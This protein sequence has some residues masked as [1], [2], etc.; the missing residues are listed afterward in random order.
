[1]SKQHSSMT[2]SELHVPFNSGLDANKAA[3][4][5]VNNWYYAT[6]TKRLYF[7][8]IAGTWIDFGR[9]LVPA[10]TIIAFSAVTPPSGYLYCNGQS[11]LRAD[12]ADLFTAIGTS[13]GAA[14][15]T[16]FNVPDLRGR[17]LRGKDDSQSRD[18]NSASR[19]AMAT[20][21]AT[22]DNIGSVQTDAMQGHW[23]ETWE[24]ANDNA[25]TGSGSR[26]YNTGANTSHI[27]D[28][29]VRAPIADGTNGTPRTASETR[30]I[31]A[32]VAF[33]IKY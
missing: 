14:D 22:G 30:P 20:G 3:S 4:P 16:H 19:T 13:F 21:G 10:G 15:G 33:H 9:N 6:D 32:Y 23:H 2:G 7:C 26:T 31:N 25:A 11:L 1:M 12:Y 17:F 24:H 5:S 8:A 29:S 27:A 18:P 28:D